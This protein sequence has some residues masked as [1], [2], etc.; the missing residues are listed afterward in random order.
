MFAGTFEQMP[1][2]EVVRLLCASA[3]T[4][5]LVILEP[6]SKTEVGQLYLQMGQMVDASQGGRGGLDAVQEL[7]RWVTAE[8]RFDSGVPAPRQSLVAYPTEKLVEKIRARSDEI[9]QM[10]R[11]MPGP[12]DLP[13][14]QSGRDASGLIVGPDELALLLLCTGERTVGQI[15]QLSGLP[16]DAVARSLARFRHVGLVDLAASPSSKEA[17]PPSLIESTSPAASKPVRYWRGHI[18][19]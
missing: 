5:V 13:I 19:E 6:E 11:L 9:L 4:G 10:S 18:V 7:C 12:E 3:Q 8:F 15:A 16:A 14:Y 17:A 2:A 1:F